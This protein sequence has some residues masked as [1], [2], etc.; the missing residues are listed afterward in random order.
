[1]EIEEFEAYKKSALGL[2]SSTLRLVGSEDGIGRKFRDKG[3]VRQKIGLVLM[4]TLRGVP[5]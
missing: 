4:D 2:V 3:V 5:G 1:M